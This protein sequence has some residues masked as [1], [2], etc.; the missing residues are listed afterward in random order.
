[1]T[2]DKFRQALAEAKTAQEIYDAIVKQES[3]L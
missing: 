2:I 1:M 3:A